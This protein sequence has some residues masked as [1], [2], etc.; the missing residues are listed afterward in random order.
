MP[1]YGRLLGTVMGWQPSIW[2]GNHILVPLSL[3][4]HSWPH[5]HN[6]PQCL[7]LASGSLPAGSTATANKPGLFCSPLLP[8]RKP[9]DEVPAF[10]EPTAGH[11]CDPRVVCTFLNPNFVFILFLIP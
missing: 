4:H 6:P 11:I 5:R 10:L 1:L 9:R 3:T 8:L 7:S 2:T